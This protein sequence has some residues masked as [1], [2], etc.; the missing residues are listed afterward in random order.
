MLD[1]LSEAKK[2]YRQDE[3]PAGAVVVCDGEIIAGAHNLVAANTDPSAHAELLALR[4]A[5]DKLG[6]KWLDN[7]ALYVTLE[8]CAM[9][10]GAI[11][12]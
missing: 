2:A 10:M 11:I 9:C 7:C 12:N 1:A 3:V 5:S 4:A 8:P 6:T